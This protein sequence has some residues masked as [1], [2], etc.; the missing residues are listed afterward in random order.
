MCSMMVSGGMALAALMLTGSAT[1]QDASRFGLQ[2]GSQ[3][4]SVDLARKAWC[5]VGEDGSCPISAIV[6]SNPAEIVLKDYV[7]DNSLGGVDEVDS[8]II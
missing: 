7:R 8:Q 5:T 2:C 1:A 6:R 4:L 3:R